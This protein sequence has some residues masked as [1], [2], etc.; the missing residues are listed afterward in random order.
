MR[1]SEH[2]SETAFREKLEGCID[3]ISLSHQ[4]DIHYDDVGLFGAG[5]RKSLVARRRNAGDLEAGIEQRRFR[6][7]RYQ[8]IVLDNQYLF[9]PRM[10]GWRASRIR[11]KRKSWP[12]ESTAKLVDDI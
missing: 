4:A 9:A 3:A 11:R 2:R 6:L 12:S 7:D 8:M 10:C 1:G 5:E